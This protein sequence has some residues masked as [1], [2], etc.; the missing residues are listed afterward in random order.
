[1]TFSAS[2]FYRCGLALSQSKSASLR[3]ACRCS[4]VC[5]NMSFAQRQTLT[6]ILLPSHRTHCAAANIRL[7]W[8]IQWSWRTK[9]VPAALSVRKRCSGPRRTGSPS[10]SCPTS[11]S[12]VRAFYK[13]PPFDSIA[14]IT[15]SRRVRSPRIS[16]DQHHVGQ[17]DRC[18]YA[19]VRGAVLPQRARQVL[20]DRQAVG[21]GAAV[22]SKSLQDVPA[23]FG[24]WK[25]RAAEDAVRK[26]GFLIG[27][28]IDPAGRR[29]T[30][31]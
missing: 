18:Q 20:E 2:A 5:S 7:R 3:G 8:G 26:Q 21:Q 11:T 6:I 14:A 31:D 13:S 15:G 1:M 12:S 9:R 17:H 25:T 29:E 10:R 22:R 19:R 30:H 24:F 23:L 28:S 4:L 27:S 16:R